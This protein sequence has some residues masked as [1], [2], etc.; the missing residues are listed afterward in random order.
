[1]L[2]IVTDDNDEQDLN[3][4]GL[5]ASILDGIIIPDNLR[6]PRKAPYL[7]IVVCSEIVIEEIPFGTY[8]S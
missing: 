3:S 4:P 1:M 7:I 5:I 2:G 8:N 6:Q